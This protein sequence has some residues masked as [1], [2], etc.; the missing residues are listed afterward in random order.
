[1]RNF[2]EIY[3]Y[4][5]SKWFK[6]IYSQMLNSD[7]I[8]NYTRWKW[9]CTHYTGYNLFIS[10]SIP[11]NHIHGGSGQNNF[12]NDNENDVHE[13]FENINNQNLFDFSNQ[14]S[15]HSEYNESEGSN[16]SSIYCR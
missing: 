3:I 4:R 16:V 1:M 12:N 5:I 11:E 15:N 10:D 6:F 13:S 2:V 14:Y 8:I 9:F 7:Y